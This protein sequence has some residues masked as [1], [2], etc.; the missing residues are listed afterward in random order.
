MKITKEYELEQD[1]CVKR[2]LKG[3][4]TNAKCPVTLERLNVLRNFVCDASNSL[5]VGSG[6]FEPI[7]INAT[8]ALDIPLCTYS[9]L[10]E[11]GWKGTF[12][13]GSCDH[14]P[15]PDKF[16]EAAVC[17]EVIEHL[18]DL[19]TVRNTFLEV[20]RVAKRWLFTTP[21]RDVKEPTHKFIFTEAQLAELSRNLNARIERKGLFFYIHNHERSVLN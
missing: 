13:Q 17:S 11:K 12:Y 19:E 14:L 20:S 16:F 3:Y 7:F 10:K 21:T 6:A 8:H 4:E 5:S 1:D 18:P 2:N 15:F 9:L